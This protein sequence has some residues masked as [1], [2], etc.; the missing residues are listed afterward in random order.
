LTGVQR[1]GP[2]HTIELDSVAVIIGEEELITIMLPAGYALCVNSWCIVN[3]WW[4]A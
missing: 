1:D 2:E 4:R 3:Y